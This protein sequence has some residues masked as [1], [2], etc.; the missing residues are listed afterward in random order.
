MA[1]DA[2]R[3]VAGR[4]GVGADHNRAGAGRADRLRGTGRDGQSTYWNGFV[5]NDQRRN[6]KCQRL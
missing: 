2:R 1:S 5:Y 6:H 3:R 4:A